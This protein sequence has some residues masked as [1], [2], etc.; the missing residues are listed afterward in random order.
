[1]DDAEID[2]DAGL[3][4]LSTLLFKQETLEGT[5]QRIAAVAARC[6]CSSGTGAGGGASVLLLSGDEP[7]IATAT[8]DR[9]RAVDQHWL[10]ARE[11]PVI[12]ALKT[13]ETVVACNVGADER[14]PDAGPTACALGLLAAVSVPLGAGAD[15]GGEVIGALTVYADQAGAFGSDHVVAAELVAAQASALVVNMQTHAECQERIRQLQEA[16]DSR[17]VIEQAKG[18]LMERHRADPQQA[19]RL[20]RERSQ[21]ENRRLRLVAEDLVLLAS[22]A[23]AGED[24]R[25]G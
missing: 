23:R 9:V 1:M 16:L 7:Y 20:L 14:Y 2:V 13:G 17:V 8:D 12:D 10:D 25:R 15:Q 19:F 6:V 22:G 3:R 4:E 21:R 24:G 5:M 11:G 18:I